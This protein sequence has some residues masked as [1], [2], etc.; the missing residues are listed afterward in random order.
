MFFNNYRATIRGGQQ[1]HL[2]YLYALLFSLSIFLDKVS[3]SAS[4]GQNSILSFFRIQYSFRVFFT[5]EG[6]TVLTPCLKFFSAIRIQFPWT[7]SFSL[8]CS[9]RYPSVIDYL[10]ICY[11][12]ALRLSM[13]LYLIAF[14]EY[15]ANF[16]GC[17]ASAL[18]RLR[19]EAAPAQ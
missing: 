18:K 13:S 9:K 15:I 3:Y 2:K 7:Y 4:A 11:A 5:T 6:I 8:S 12:F 16:E 17:F 1:L 14:I 19:G 10:H